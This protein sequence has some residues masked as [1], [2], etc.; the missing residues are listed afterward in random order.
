MIAHSFQIV[1]SIGLFSESE[2]HLNW[3]QRE[4]EGMICMLRILS[5]VTSIR[6]DEMKQELFENGLLELAISNIL[7]LMFN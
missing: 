4:W 1:T 6:N 3:K 7:F 5:L 2:E